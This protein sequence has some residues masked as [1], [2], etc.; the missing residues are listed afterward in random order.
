[1]MDSWVWVE[2][3]DQSLIRYALSS[4]Y[5]YYM[6]HQ[7]D[8]PL[9]ILKNPHNQYAIER[10]IKFGSQNERKDKLARE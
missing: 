1:M 6:S 5:M 8:D 3:S 9:D 7:E 10:A 4:L 2:V